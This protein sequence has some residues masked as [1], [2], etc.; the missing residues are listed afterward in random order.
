M[1][2]INWPGIFPQTFTHN[3]IQA[4]PSEPLVCH[5]TPQSSIP[6]IN[7]TTPFF[8]CKA[9]DAP[10]GRNLGKFA[11]LFHLHISSRAKRERPH[12]HHT[13]EAYLI[14]KKYHG[15]SVEVLKK[16]FLWAFFSRVC[17]CWRPAGR[18]YVS[19]QKCIF[20]KQT[21]DRNRSRSIGW[22][23]CD[24]NNNK[25]K[26]TSVSASLSFVSKHFFCTTH[27]VQL[28]DTRGMYSKPTA[29]FGWTAMFA[30]Q[31]IWGFQKHKTLCRSRLWIKK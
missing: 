14:A 22:C 6:P 5:H 31:T 2:T 21:I 11:K 9:R 18:I 15:R 23:E 28:L 30:Y 13:C 27:K 8:L 29:V 16:R 17:G 12:T 24:I 1:T 3:N 7:T 19:I 25:G 4:S 20:Q 26:E 10:S